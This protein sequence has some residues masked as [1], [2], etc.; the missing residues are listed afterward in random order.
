MI[1][2]SL[3]YPPWNVPITFCYHTQA[4]VISTWV[5]SISQNQTRDFHASSVLE[6]R[7]RS[8]RRVPSEGVTALFICGVINR[9]LSWPCFG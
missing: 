7:V 5:S 9:V 1:T 3:S 2:M 8:M 6:Q 4:L